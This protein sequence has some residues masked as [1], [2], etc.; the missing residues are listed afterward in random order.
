M[1][2]AHK[3]VMDSAAALGFTGVRL[4]DLTEIGIEGSQRVADDSLILN[5]MRVHL[6]GLLSNPAHA[7]N[8]QYKSCLQVG[9][10]AR[11]TNSQTKISSY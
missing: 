4:T 9:L 5:Q 10:P 6:E 11:R 1:S 3:Q 7:A 2:I 8:A